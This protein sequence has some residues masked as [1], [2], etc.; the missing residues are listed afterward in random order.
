MKNASIYFSVCKELAHFP[1][2]ITCEFD[3]GILVIQG[4]SGSGKTTLLNCLSGIDKP[5]S[6]FFRVNGR[7][8]FSSR[9]RINVPARSR[10]LSYLFQNY[11]LFPHMTVYQN[12]V[13]G[14]K[15][16]P[17][18]KNTR[19]KKELL[20]YADHAIESFGISHLKN[21]PANRI[22]GGEKQRVALCRAIVTNPSL[23]L[24]DEPFSALDRKTKL[25]IYDEFEKFKETYRIPAILITHD[26]YES[27]RFAD[28]RIVISEG[29]LVD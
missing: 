12:I 15:N 28:H 18:Y 4:E 29:R 27:E 9:D 25:I 20:D 16:Q 6:G 21:K 7:I 19:S 11:A 10:N 17:E 1:L 24:L 26:P 23:L 22:S 13:Y 5:D 8:L 14:I 2:D 3:S